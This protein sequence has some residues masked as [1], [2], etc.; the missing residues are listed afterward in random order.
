MMVDGT[1]I[2]DLI[3]YVNLGVDRLMIL[4]VV[5]DQFSSLRTDF[6]RCPYNTFAL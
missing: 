6:R 5:Q 4:W 3:T 2:P 1:G